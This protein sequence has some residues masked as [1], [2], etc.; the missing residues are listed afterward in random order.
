MSTRLSAR[1]SVFLCALWALWLADCGGR[2][3]VDEPGRFEPLDAGT[4]DVR[5]GGDAGLLDPCSRTEQCE[6]A[7]G[8][9]CVDTFPGGL[10]SR[11]CATDSD[12]RGTVP[13]PN[14][15]GR[16][17]AGICLPSCFPGDHDCDAFQGVCVGVSSDNPDDLSGVCV[18]GCVAPGPGRPVATTCRDGLVCD[19]YNGACVA[20][21]PAGG[22]NG[23]PCRD[24]VDCKGE[25]LV[26]EGT[27]GFVGGYC[28]SRA[29]SVPEEQQNRPGPRPRSNCPAGSAVYFFPFS[30]EGT[31]C[32]RE[33]S[34][35]RDCRP[36]YA[37]DYG[38]TSGFTYT[39][40]LCQPINCAM[41]GAACP[42]GYA[43][44]RSDSGVLNRCVRAR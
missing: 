35:D 41:A 21:P 1:T 12:C 33:C 40:G 32:F 10:C 30:D 18:P 31:I 37:C 4:L 11:H 44:A 13:R 42:A 8:A 27:L 9:T 15:L 20:T 29:R 19:E 23:D 3:P 26:D 34:A 5:H 43:C 28:F 38:T 7:P 14:R 16:C 22:E 36:G 39:T 25:C 17:V 24:D 6:A 2:R